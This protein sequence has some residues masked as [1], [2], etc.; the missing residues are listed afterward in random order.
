MKIAFWSPVHG[1]AGTSSNI[2]GMALCAGMLYR[3]SSILMQTHFGMNNLEAPLVGSNTK[4]KA[5]SEY[6]R[7]VGLD[8]LVRNFKSSRLSQEMLYNC[9]ITLLGTN[10]SLLPGTA[11]NNIKAYEHEMEQVLLPLLKT[12]E[13]FTQLLLIDVNSGYHPIA[14]K[15]LGA[16]ELKVINLSQ[17]M[18]IL[19]A[20]LS[21]IPIQLGANV[22]Y[23]FGN[24]D[25]NSKYNIHNLR[26]RYFKHITASNSAVIPYHTHYRDSQS[27]GKVVEFIKSNLYCNNKDENYS[28]SHQLQKAVSK[29]LKAAG[30]DVVERKGGI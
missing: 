6:F 2:M 7:D 16:C 25:E 9:C 24:Y 13:D 22:F 17:N 21:N 29:I 27:D 8:A 5:S 14:L 23:L 4:S 26:R 10:V 3:K 30:M 20:Y 15:I 28:F 19:E 18:D 12:M 11:K 1:Q